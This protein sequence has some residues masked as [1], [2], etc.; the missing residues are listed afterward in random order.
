MQLCIG[1]GDLT[2][3]WIPFQYFL[4]TRAA[5]SLSYGPGILQ[6][7]C[8]GVPV[9]FF[10]VA[11]NDLN[12][13]RTSGRDKFIAKIKKEIQKPDDYNEDPEDG[14]GPWRQKFEEIE[15]SIVDN[16]D[17]SYKVQYQIDE[18]CEVDVHV[19][20][21]DDKGNLVAIR[22]SPYKASFSKA[23][24]PA[25]N[26]MSGPLMQ[27][28]FKQQVSDLNDYM[29]KKEKSISLKGKDMTEV[30]TLLSVKEETEEVFKNENKT[31]LKIDQLDE[32]MKMFA[33]AVPKVKVDSS[34][35]GKIQGNW[36]NVKNNSKNV[37]KTIAPIVEQ[38]DG[39]NKSNIKTLEEQII[40]FTQEMRKRPFFQYKTGAK[41]SIEKLADVF[42]E[43]KGF[44]DSKDLYG[45]NARKFGNP[46]LIIKAVKDIEA[47]KITV[48]NMKALWDHIETCQ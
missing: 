8:A 16:Q 37:K 48:D 23:A 1:S 42:G 34:K 47:I 44:E 35:F 22:G 36:N 21:E 14:E 10:V 38:Q 28:H 39:I 31:T 30:P 11:R 20:F 2:T 18:E 3:T 5:K 41:E 32:S 12:E 45:D 33:A 17:G 24:K 7:C 4:N 25:D 26:T 46:D 40:Q 27:A 6:N 15:C 29:S 9:E 43:L 19:N 13:N